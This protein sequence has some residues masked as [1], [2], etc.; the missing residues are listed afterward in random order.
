MS[1]KKYS[2]FWQ[3]AMNQIQEEYKNKNALE[4]FSLWFNMNYENDSNDT[5][6]VSVPSKFLW[7]TM[8]KKGF[9]SKV[10]KIIQTLTGQ[11]NI[12]IEHIVKKDT[13]NENN[14]SSDKSNENQSKESKEKKNVSSKKTEKPVETHP[15]L[16]SS[17]TFDSFIY[18]ENNE[19]AYRAAFAV[20]QNP[21]KKWNPLLLYGGVG[22]GKTHLMQAIG[23]YIYQEN[24][25][26]SKICYIS[27]ESF[28]N[29]FTASLVSKTQRS[30]QTKYR[31]LDVLLL[32][33]IHFLQ[34]KPGTQ[35]EMFYVFNALRDRNAQLVFTC[36]RPITELKEFEKRLQ[37]RISNGLSADMQ[38]PNYET[39]VAIINK[40]LSLSENTI[41]MDVI[42]YIA[43]NIE[44][45][46][47]DLEAA[48]NKMIGYAELIQKPLT[49]EIAKEQ[50]HDIFSGSFAENISIETI[51]KVVAEEYQIS[52][53]DLKGKKRD[54]KFVTP[55]HI[56]LYLSRELT[57]S[58]FT[59]IGNEF[60]G[61]DHSTIMHAY[62]KIEG[63]IKFDNSLQSR[64]KLL[65]EKIKKSKR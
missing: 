46:V 9:V 7:D 48:L 4:D 19:L 23:N 3:E 6:T 17:F 20:A 43:K 24:G 41:P 38:M 31:N 29:E 28:T 12:Q 15:Q 55:R 64:I 34:G 11:K 13:S 33:D 27:A 25:G 40:K 53:S 36:D 50:L 60:G 54:K 5:I 44:T 58:S 52:V 37:S 57:E 10:E 1:S 8:Q 35:E 32:D 26:K 62:E 16:R 51:Q 49:I 30:F 21:G 59:E 63:E 65:T 42:D 2:E 18:G 45:N 61:R 56:A 39:R 47:R 22:L 14:S